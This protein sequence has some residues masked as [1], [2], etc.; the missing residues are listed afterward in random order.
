LSAQSVDPARCAPPL[1]G[2]G[3][4]A[5]GAR[6]VRVSLRPADAGDFD[7]GFEVTE[8]AMRGYIEQTW[9]RWDEALHR[10]HHAATFKADTHRVILVAGE[11][12]G[13][14]AVEQQ[15]EHVQLEKLYLLPGARNRGVGSQ[16]LRSVLQPAIARGQSVR[17]RV[18]A[19]NTPAQRFYA[20]HGF[21]VVA[22]TPERL[23]MEAGGSHADSSGVLPDGYR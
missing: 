18:L 10:R 16:V 15:A 17:L 13:I 9:G 14:L 12:A 19:V 8:L 3:A 7:F 1:P 20:R 5:R 2:S 4:S 22:V 21:V 23:F 11:R 6:E